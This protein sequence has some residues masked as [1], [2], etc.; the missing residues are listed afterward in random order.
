MFNPA[1]GNIVWDTLVGPGTSLGG[2]EWGSAYD[3]LRIYTAEADPFGV[4]YALRNGTTR[5]RGR[6]FVGGARPADR[7]QS[8]GRRQRPAATAP[9]GP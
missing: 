3:G 7:A 4:P 8:T 6:W 5:Q 9:S 1:N 2:L